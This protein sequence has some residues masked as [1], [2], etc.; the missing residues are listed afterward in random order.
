MMSRAF[1]TT[2]YNDKEGIVSLLSSLMIQT[3]APDEIII[4]DAGSKDATFEV[5]NSYKDR[6]GKKLKVF[7]KTGNRSKGRNFAIKNAKS[8][9]IAVSDSGCSL[10]KD[11]FERITKPLEDGVEVVAGYYHPVA[12][13]V[14]QKSLATYT[15][16]MPDKVGSDFLP[17]SRSIAFLKKSWKKVGGYPEKLNTCEDLVFARELK[18]SGM[19]FEVVKSAVVYWPQRNTLKEAFLQFFSYAKGDGEALYFRKSTPFLFLRYFVGLILLLTAIIYG[20]QLLALIIVFLF[21]AYLLWAVWKNYK[22]VRKIESLYYLS[23]LQLTSDLAV[24]SGTTLGLYK[25]IF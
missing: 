11:W 7:K 22:Y 2:V 1:I 16:V 25:R 12:R 24:L 14:F 23:V 21:L 9:I 13:N 8:D 17:S 3:V 6:F 10:K 20:S 19:R 5:I 18:K 15:S 4:V